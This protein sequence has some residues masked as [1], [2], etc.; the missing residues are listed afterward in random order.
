VNYLL[1]NYITTMK[2][3]SFMIMSSIAPAAKRNT[4]LT[5]STDCLYSFYNFDADAAITSAM[6]VIAFFAL[7][8]TYSEII[9][10]YKHMK[11]PYDR[12]MQDIQYSRT[13]EIW[14][15]NHG[16]AKTFRSSGT[17]TKVMIGAMVKQFSCCASINKKRTSFKVIFLMLVLFVAATYFWFA[18]N[19]RT[20]LVVYQ[21][22]FI[23][24]SN[25]KVMNHPNTFPAWIAD[26]IGS[27]WYREGP[28]GSV[29]RR[30]WEKSHRIK[31]PVNLTD[32]SEGLSASN[33]E[34]MVEKISKQEIVLMV[35]DYIALLVHA[36]LC[37][38]AIMMSKN[39]IILRK[40]PD[41]PAASMALSYNHLMPDFL[42]EVVDVVSKRG[43]LAAQSG[44]IHK[45]SIPTESP[46][47][48]LDLPADVRKCL[49][50]VLKP[51]EKK[52]ITTIRSKPIDDFLYFC[53]LIGVLLLVSLLIL[54]I[55]RHR[56]KCISP[57]KKEGKIITS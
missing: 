39:P 20:E 40:D 19:I 52:E 51:E 50:S 14:G 54:S 12:M 47:A 26:V 1:V 25:F 6:F 45:L 16:D 57:R 37:P 53:Y 7:M 2:G 35:T 28:A 17:A 49:N 5:S 3:T 15:M 24:D 48:S 10:N 33:S 18:S 46:I 41:E 29:R 34:P 11:R 22:P 23:F 36:A 55:E 44:I 30:M 27:G 4:T 13:F 42:P 38:L 56:A 31:C 21:Q 9:R 32:C 43:L 8:R